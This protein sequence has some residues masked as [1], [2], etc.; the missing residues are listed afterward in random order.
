MS[1]PYIVWTLRRTGGTTLAALLGTL[2]EH[3][4]VPHEPFNPDRT[5]GHVAVQWQNNR[6]PVLLREAMQKVLL[7]RPVIKHC[8]EIVEPAL[9]R[10][11]M[12][13]S[14]EFG[15]R[16]IVLDRR[17][18]VERILSLELAKITGVWGR[19]GSWKVYEQ[20]KAGTIRLDP[21]RIPEAVHHLQYCRGRRAAIRDHFE[22]LGI[23]PF[24][25]YFEDV[26]RDPAEGR[27]LVAS[28]LDFLGIKPEQRPDYEALLTEALMRKGQ[29]S[30]RVV[31]LIP[32]INETRSALEAAWEQAYT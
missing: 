10:C 20:I 32:N 21:V 2:S 4:T 1:F 16:H 22:K 23:A 5:F 13:V 25:V 12:E 18:E 31:D 24:D 15:Y 17:S 30:A 9:N 28:L 14:H 8:H 7:D 11:L 27:K 3:P 19:Q 29:N 26:Y 6:D